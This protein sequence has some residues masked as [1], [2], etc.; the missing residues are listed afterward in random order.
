IPIYAHEQATKRLKRKE[1]FLQTRIDFFETLYR[2]MGCGVE[3]TKQVEKLKKAKEA[4][5]SQKIDG[6]IKTLKEGDILEGFRVLE[7]QGH[8]KDQIALL[9]EESGIMFAG[10]HIM[11]R[12]PVNPLVEPDS[13]ANKIPVVTQYEKS[14]KKLQ[15]YK[16]NR[17]YP[18]H[19]DI[20]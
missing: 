5:R 18:G 16:M 13:K 10:D 6:Q 20:I 3:G 17:I 19:G 11:L 14:L 7:V 8:A 2:Q 1:T 4:N 15:H 12:T 9:H